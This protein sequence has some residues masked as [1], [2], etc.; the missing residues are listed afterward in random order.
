MIYRKRATASTTLHII[1]NKFNMV[2]PHAAERYTSSPCR[3][4]NTAEFDHVTESRRGRSLQ[5]VYGQ[6]RGRQHHERVAGGRP[7]PGEKLRGGIGCY[8]IGNSGGGPKGRFYTVLVRQADGSG[9]GTIFQCTGCRGCLPALH[10]TRLGAEVWAGF[11]ETQQMHQSTLRLKL[12]VL[13]FAKR[14]L[15]ALRCTTRRSSIV[16]CVAGLRRSLWQ[17]S[18]A[19]ARTAKA[20]SG[21]CGPAGLQKTGLETASCEVGKMDSVHATTGVQT[22]RNGK[23]ARNGDIFLSWKK[24]HAGACHLKVTHELMLTTAFLS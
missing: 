2:D 5:E 21:C 15:T 12:R 13:H 16:D 24:D 20:W 11:W 14:S 19:S 22:S 3:G 10:R 1:M 9:A 6:G 23:E 18:S 4:V 8:C 7:W 17:G